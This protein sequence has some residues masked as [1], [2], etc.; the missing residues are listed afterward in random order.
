MFASLYGLTT[1]TPDSDQKSVVTVKVR[2]LNKATSRDDLRDHLSGFNIVDINLIQIQGDR[3]NYAYVN[4]PDHST[5]KKVAEAIHNKMVIHGNLLRAILREDN[6]PSAAIRE[7]LIGNVANNLVEIIY[8]KSKVES[9]VVKKHFAKYGEVESVTIVQQGSPSLCHVRFSTALSA[10]VARYE[11]PYHIDFT[12][13]VALPIPEQLESQSEF[14][15]ESFECD[16]LVIDTVKDKLTNGFSDTS[17]VIFYIHRNSITG[18]FYAAMSTEIQRRVKQIV[19]E[20]ESKISETLIEIHH[21][22]IPIVVSA[23]YKMSETKTW[24]L[25]VK[26]GT[27][28]VPLFYLNCAYDSCTNSVEDGNISPYLSLSKNVSHQTHYKWYWQDDK[29]IFQGYT[30]EVNTRFELN[31]K[32]TPYLTQEIGR[33]VYSINF[34]NMTQTNVTTGK[35]RTIKREEMPTLGDWAWTLKI[36]APETSI[37]ECKIRV[38]SIIKSNTNIAKLEVPNLALHNDSF[39]QSIQRMRKQFLKITFEGDQNSTLLIQGKDILVQKAL[40]DLQSQIL[41]IVAEK[42]FHMAIPNTWEKQSSK[43]ELKNVMRGTIEWKNIEDKMLKPNFSIKI[44]KIERIQNTWLWE[45][46][47]LS[48]KRMS[49]KN[50]GEVN[51]KSL[52]HGTRLTVPKDIYDSEQGF[53]NRLASKGWWGEGTYFAESA[54]Y[55]DGYAHALEDGHKQMFLVQVVTGIPCELS[56]LDQ[57]LKAPP[58]KEDH[59]SLFTLLYAPKF[60]GERYDS[61]TGL[62]INSKIYVIYELGRVYPAYLITYM[63]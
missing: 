50:N 5:A 17:K 22:Y 9:A 4:L 36:K 33:H 34:E 49:E 26:Q 32:T 6:N 37:Q 23:R 16:P 41:E 13:A 47:Q 8:C 52:F 21:S 20:A 29:T 15:T 61:V 62:S 27:T 19:T 48:K 54:K 58:K 3:V 2:N 31:L 14:T 30:E 35:K 39:H 53:D 44:M 18:T 59:D 43:C 11:S 51:E 12:T 45:L 1:P 46:Y 40:S 25:S 55:S 63:K 60:E 42:S 56:T 57:S 24:E 10:H 7:K 38:C 28:Y